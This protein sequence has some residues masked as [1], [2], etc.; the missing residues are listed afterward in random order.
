MPHHVKGLSVSPPPLLQP[1]RLL[2]P[3][4]LCSCTWA[5]LGQPVQQAKSI[6]SHNGDA[7]RSA[8]FPSH[9]AQLPWP[10]LP[11]LGSAHCSHSRLRKVL[12]SWRT[13]ICPSERG[14]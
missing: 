14:H 3:S 4:C 7:H 9:L 5:Q 12:K 10:C 2:S 6:C 1:Q 8:N 13:N 11:P